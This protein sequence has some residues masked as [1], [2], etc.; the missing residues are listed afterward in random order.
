MI[1]LQQ[2][3]AYLQEGGGDWRGK[4]GRT[5]AVDTGIIGAAYGNGQIWRTKLFSDMETLRTAL[6]EEEKT[7]DPDTVAA[8][9]LA[10]PFLG[11]QKQVVLVLYAECN[12]LNFF[13]DDERIRRVVAMSRGFC[14][15]FDWLQKD[16]FSNLRNFP[17]QKGT[18]IT[19][20]GGLYSVQESV[21][22]IVP[23]AF[24]E[25]PSFNY[26]AAAA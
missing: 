2:A 12:E 16:P 6:R 17:L 25:V 19:G 14:K 23:P 15:L 22:S 5:F 9:Y 11:P 20:V 8:A 4:V 13:A 1:F 7:R 3:C 26:E 21:P 24:T 18:P 10:I